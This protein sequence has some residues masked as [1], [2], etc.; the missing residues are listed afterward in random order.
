[1]TDTPNHN[2][3][4]ILTK[5]FFAV[6]RVIVGI[7]L[8]FSLYLYLFFPYDR[9]RSFAQKEAREKLG[10]RLKLGEMYFSLFD[11]LVVRDISVTDPPFPEQ[12]LQL[13]TVRVDY[14]FWAILSGKI[15]IDRIL[16]DAPKINLRYR[17]G[18]W[19]IEHITARLKKTPP[20]QPPEIVPEKKPEVAGLPLEIHLEEFVIRNPEI[21]LDKPGEF[22]INISGINIR[23]E[24]NLQE[25]TSYL[26]VAFSAPEQNAQLAAT[27]PDISITSRPELDVQIQIKD[28]NHIAAEGRIGLND[29][30]IAVDK[31]IPP[32]TLV[33]GI[34]AGV[35]LSRELCRISLLNITLNRTQRI[36]LSADVSELLTAPK[37]SAVI[38]KVDLDLE[39]LMR[40][41]SAF[42]PEISL[43]G[44]VALKNLHVEGGIEKDKTADNKSE[45]VPLPLR[46]SQ[47]S[48]HLKGVDVEIPSKD[49]KFEGIEGEFQL[50]QIVLHPAQILPRT[51][52]L[53]LELGCR[54]AQGPGFHAEEVRGRLNFDGDGENLHKNQ[55][56]LSVSL[57]G[58][59]VLRSN[60]I[61]LEGITLSGDISDIKLKG[62]KPESAKLALN[63]R[64]RSGRISDVSLAGANVNITGDIRYPD[65]SESAISVKIDLEN[66][67]MAGKTPVRAAGFHADILLDDL[68]FTRNIFPS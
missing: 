18:A 32:L 10:V 1:M 50:H 46:L 8:L 66:A 37:V 4:I 27:L 55:T 14:S 62:D 64:V 67:E 51:A 33:A 6:V 68:L 48:V 54:K 43:V 56:R 38:E 45:I 61:R 3:R 21:F 9:V 59:S 49:I 2:S 34:K 13:D 16:F 5:Y 23:V 25:S 20:P 57:A 63:T 58:L 60:P 36:R 22:Q 31:E 15:H 65:L 26:T 39:R 52:R 7:I 29:V 11:G 19:N 24:G 44:G 30:R 42:V 47:G 17:E 40:V 41:A 28:F 53:A 12:V 35:D